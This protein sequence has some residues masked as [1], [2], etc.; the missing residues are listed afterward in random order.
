[1]KRFEIFNLNGILSER[2][3]VGKL[4]KDEMISFLTLKISL[5]DISET[6]RK[7]IEKLRKESNKQFNIEEGVEVSDE[8]RNEASDTFNKM[9]DD[10]LQEDIKEIDSHILSS[11]DIYNAILDFDENKSVSIN[12][13]ANIFKYLKK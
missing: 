12:D 2:L 7:H 5:E 3:K 9:V 8:V 6:I 13:K 1:M 4:N 10:Y 11:D